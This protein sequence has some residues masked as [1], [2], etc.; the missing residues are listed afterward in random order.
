[1]TLVFTE[2]A[3]CHG[4]TAEDIHHVMTYPLVDCSKV[5]STFE[6]GVCASANSTHYFVEFCKAK[7]LS[8]PAK[9]DSKAHQQ[10]FGIRV[11]PKRNSAGDNV[12]S[13]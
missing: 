10:V 8:Y 11:Q 1:M 3:F 9:P 5:L 6:L 12:Q 4:F 13:G 7:L 2:S